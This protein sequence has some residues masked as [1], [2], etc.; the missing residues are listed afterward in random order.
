MD[1]TDYDID[2]AN[3]RID[4]LRKAKKILKV[5]FNAVHGIQSEDW[6]IKRIVEII[7]E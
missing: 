7:E 2:Q 5:S 1:K 6:A 4:N 3:K